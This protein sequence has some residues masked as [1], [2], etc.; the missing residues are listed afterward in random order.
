M[1]NVAKTLY[2]RKCNVDVPEGEECPICGKTPPAS[3]VRVAWMYARRRATDWMSWNAVMRIAVPV[4]SAATALGLLLE[5][6][7]GGGAGVRQLIASG[8]LWAMGLL[9]L[10][11]CAVTL[12]VF[13]LGGDDELYCVVDSK[14]FHVRTA[15]PA[16]NRVRLLLHGKSADLMTTADTNG[17]VILGEKSLAWKDIARVQLWTDKRLMLLYSPRWWMKLSV[18]ILLAKWNDV[19]TMT[20][21]KLGKKKAVELPEDWQ[22]QLPPQRVSDKKPRKTDVD[23][24]VIP[25]QTTLPENE[26]DYRPLDEVLSEL[27]G[28]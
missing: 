14:G 11:V 17:R 9:M 2:C 4:L 25:P 24:S 10:L 6:L 22:H 12:L 7:L 19:L 16:A 26:E 20:D 13:A 18:P 28:K 15:L 1:N 21:E 8:F 3:S 23:A 5:L 27:R